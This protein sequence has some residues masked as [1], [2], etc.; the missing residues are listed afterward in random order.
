VAD[1]DLTPSSK[2]KRRAVTAKHLDLL[3]GLYG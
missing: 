1:G 3:D 2:L